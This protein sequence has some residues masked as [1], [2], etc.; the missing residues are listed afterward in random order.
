MKKLLY[1]FVVLCVLCSTAMPKT[2]SNKTFL[3]PR[4]QLNNLPMEYTTWHKNLYRKS[5]TLYNGTFQIVPFYQESDNKSDIG[6]YFGFDRGGTTGIVNQISVDEEGEGALLEN[7]FIIHDHNTGGGN[8]NATYKFDPYQEVFGARLSLNQDL[9]AIL[10]GLFFRINTPIVK[11]RNDMNIT[12]IGTDTKQELPGVA[13]GT[14]KSFLDYLS[15]NV[16]NSTEHNL[17]A[18]LNYAKMDSGSHS[19]SGI[20]DIDVMLGYTFWEKAN[21]RIAINLA[22]L[23]P[24]GKT[25]KGEFI[26]EPV[27]GC[28]QHWGLGAGLDYAL[29]LWKTKNKSIALSIVANYKYLFEGIEKRTL[30]FN[31]PDVNKTRAQA[32]Y[33]ELA[34]E[35]GKRGVFPFANVLTQDIRVTPGSMVDAIV[36]LAFNIK[37]FVLDLGYNLYAKESELT[38]LRYLWENDKY[39]VAGVTYNTSTANGFSVLT[40]A[41]TSQAYAY[42]GAQAGTNAS[43]N[44]KDLDFDTIT[45]P[46]QVTHK[47]YGALG[48]QW[49][50]CQYP[51]MLGIGGSYE[52]A[53]NNNA[54]EGWAIW[55]K[56]GLSW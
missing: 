55:A 7:G 9:D 12:T 10:D 19:T 8:L 2:Y 48:Y 27:H 51:V 29:T 18:P 13:E 47:I 25:P 20:A 53:Q 15:G 45:N 42:E 40:A 46:S 41:D 23:I 49:N 50:K 28:G 56:T 32:G 54:L 38:S 3:M 11:V 35:Q 6:K 17:Q 39:A 14:E 1:S 52:F 21:S 16:A 5:N 22:M 30:G 36:N 33:Y 34:G 31:R 24:T 44:N 43:I 26:F 4:D 37:G